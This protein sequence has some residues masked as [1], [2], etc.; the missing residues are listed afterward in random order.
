M[1]PNV[2][3][4]TIYNCQDIEA[5]SVHQ[6]MDKE[7]VCCV[8]MCVCVCVI[9]LSH[10]KM[11]KFPTTWVDQENAMFSDVSQTKKDNT[12]VSMAIPS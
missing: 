4:N 1:C 12:M 10:K 5:A 2:H 6:G 7:D 11:K 8:G 3:S 9:L